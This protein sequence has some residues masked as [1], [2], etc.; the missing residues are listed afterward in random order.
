VNISPPACAEC[1]KHLRSYQRRGEDWYCSVCGPVREPCSACGCIRP[2]NS[3]DRDGKPRCA[4]CPPGGGDPVVLITEVVTS[5][6]PSL[7]TETVTAAVLAAVPRSGQR[8]P[9]A[10]ALQ[11][12]P[13]LCPHCLI[14]DPANQE[15]C[16]KCGR[17]RPVAVRTPGGPLC[18]TCR[19]VPV[20]A[21]SICGRQAP[22]ETSMA[23]GRSP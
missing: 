17:C 7:D 12:Q 20:A 10:W 4:Q 5:A 21:C 1:G 18:P 8:R 9:L 16:S 23:T 15:E 22:C 11:D 19:P 2:V 3:H 13:G 6:D 14:T